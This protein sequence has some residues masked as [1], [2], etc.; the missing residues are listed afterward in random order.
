[1]A[2]VLV[3]WL[4]GWCVRCVCDFR[5]SRVAWIWLTTP[6][7]LALTHLR[8]I[9]YVAAPSAAGNAVYAFAIGCVFYFGFASNW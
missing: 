6:V 8:K 1:M 5:V 2:Q 7:L 4:V 9:K 3:G